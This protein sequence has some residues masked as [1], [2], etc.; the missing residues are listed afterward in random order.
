MYR[1][2]PGGGQNAPATQELWPSAIRTAA[3]E[4]GRADQPDAPP[5]RGLG[6]GRHDV[7]P[8]RGV[9]AGFVAISYRISA[10]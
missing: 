9:F 3:C 8:P 4:A 6:R 5:P 1:S 2:A 10:P 7:C